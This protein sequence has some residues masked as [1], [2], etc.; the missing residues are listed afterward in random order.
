[1]RVLYR[2]W[3][4]FY[5]H[6][7]LPLLATTIF[8][9]GNTIAGR[10]AV[11][12]ISPMLLTSLRW[13][14]VLT[15]LL[16]F[17]GKQLIATWP[18]FKPFSLKALWMGF[19][20]FTAFNGLFYVAA[21]TTGAANLAIIQGILPIFVMLGA[22]FVFGT[23]IRL[24]QIIGMGIA[25]VGVA[26]VGLKG[27]FSTL[28]TASFN[29][30]DLL[31]IIAC[32]LYAAYT[33]GLRNRPQIPSLVFFTAIA[34]VAFVTSLLPVVIEIYLGHFIWPTLQGGLVLIYIGVFPSLL[35]QVFFMRGVELIGPSRAGLFINLVPVFGTLMA[36]VLPSEPFAAYHVIGLILVLSGIVLAEKKPFKSSPLLPNTKRRK[37]FS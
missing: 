31:M 6:T 1:M 36:A 5:S 19:C 21:Y 14:L 33:L 35:A 20:G 27:N 22:F 34:I 2:G 9:G 32:I 11:G 23:S 25:F 12:E 30:G 4:F 13:L 16:P 26:V 10:L 3:Q 15:I 8:W 29:V 7:Y 37:N 17:T 18:I 24:V 28:Q